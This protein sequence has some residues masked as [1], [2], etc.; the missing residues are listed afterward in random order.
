[1]PESDDFSRVLTQ[2]EID[3]LLDT[4]DQDVIIEKNR[5][6]K[7]NR[8]INIPQNKKLNIPIQ[9]NPKTE[10]KCNYCGN[11][12][13]V[14]KLLMNGKNKKWILF[15]RHS[16]TGKRRCSESD[17]EYRRCRNILS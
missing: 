9:K 15:C 1:M 12:F 16:A 5:K 14:Q 7:I 2:S 3:A 4:V 6:R 8:K 11:I 17:S 10:L 13:S